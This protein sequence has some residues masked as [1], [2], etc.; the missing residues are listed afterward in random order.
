MGFVYTKQDEKVVLTLLRVLTVFFGVCIVSK[1]W[2]SLATV[3]GARLVAEAAVRDST[4]SR[5]TPPKDSVGGPG[6]VEQLRQR[7]LFTPGPPKQNPIAEVMGILGDEAFINGRWCKVGDTIGEARVLAIEA[8][9]VEVLWDGQTLVYSPADA[10]KPPTPDSLQAKRQDASSPGPKPAQER[11]L[12]TYQAPA[13]YAGTTGSSLRVSCPVRRTGPVRGDNRPRRIRQI[14]RGPSAKSDDVLA[15]SWKVIRASAA[16][17]HGKD[18]ANG[19]GSA[20]GRSRASTT[21]EGE[22]VCQAPIVSMPPRR[23]GMDVVVDHAN[24]RSRLKT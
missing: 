19:R 21:T 18:A 23:D 1:V 12:Q 6:V 8:T 17:H 24:K 15:W 3:R 7:N 2:T 9:C 14:R 11:G 20:L 10:G 22:V 4:T 16:R 5:G 13:P